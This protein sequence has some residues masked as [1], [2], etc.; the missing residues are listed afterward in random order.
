MAVNWFG[1]WSGFQL[2]FDLLSPNHDFPQQQHAI[3]EPEFKYMSR[4]KKD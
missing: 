2:I 1:T 3:I 4:G